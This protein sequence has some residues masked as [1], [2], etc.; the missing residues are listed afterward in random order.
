[1]LTQKIAENINSHLLKQH[2][3]AVSQTVTSTDSAVPHSVT[4]AVTTCDELA[5]TSA[6]DA[7]SEI[8][9]GSVQSRSTTST[10]DLSINEDSLMSALQV[11]V[12]AP[13][14]HL[15]WGIFYDVL[16]CVQKKIPLNCFLL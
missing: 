10:A 5:A 1:M 11:S 12:T 7:V 2:D 6:V 3:S 4:A 16:H 13:H 8:V 14:Q 15:M 9:A